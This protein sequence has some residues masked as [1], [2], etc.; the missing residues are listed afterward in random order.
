MLPLVVPHRCFLYRI[1]VEPYQWV[2]QA[3]SGRRSLSIA[4]VGCSGD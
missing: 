3:A 1:L 2:S 4:R